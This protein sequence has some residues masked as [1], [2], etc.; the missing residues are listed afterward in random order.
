VPKKSKNLQNGNQE[1]AVNPA[2]RRTS[3]STKKT[4]ATR[5]ARSPAQGAKA[6]FRRKSASVPPPTDEEIRLRAYFISERRHRL[7]LPGDT[8]SD[9]LEAKRQL[10]SEVGPR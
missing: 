9:W 6:S 3:T 1:A 10:F 4:K 2:R 5:K 8:S 7:D